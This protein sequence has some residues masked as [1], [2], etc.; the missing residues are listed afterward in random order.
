M[1]DIY[2]AGISMTKFGPHYEKGVKDL[3]ISK[4]RLSLHYFA[5]LHMVEK[6]FLV[7]KALMMCPSVVLE[8]L[9]DENPLQMTC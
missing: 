9:I 3:V 5:I 1:Q 8:K 7:A 6:D 4:L 2:V